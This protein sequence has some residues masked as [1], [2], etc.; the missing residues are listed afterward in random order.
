MLDGFAGT[1]ALGI[2][3]LS[4]GAAAVTFVEQDRR[5]QALIADNLAHCG[6]DDRLCYHPRAAV[7]SRPSRRS[8]PPCVSSP[9]TSSCWIRLTTDAGPTR[10]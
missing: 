1:G 7:D 2:E 3:A 8:Q 6:I 9:S 10:R 5:A 4:R